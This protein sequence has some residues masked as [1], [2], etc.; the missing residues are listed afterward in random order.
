MTEEIIRIPVVDQF[1]GIHFP[2]DIEIMKGTGILYG[3]GFGHCL[4][5]HFIEIYYVTF[6]V[7]H[8]K[9]EYHKIG[10]IFKERPAQNLSEGVTGFYENGKLKFEMLNGTLD[11]KQSYPL[12]ESWV[13]GEIDIKS[14]L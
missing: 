4:R 5:G 7:P 11:E 13:N 8:T 9:P 1:I 10:E 14:D 2:A 3:Y 6:N 12:F